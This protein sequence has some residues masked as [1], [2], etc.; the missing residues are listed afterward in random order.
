MS[1]L[2]IFDG[3][4]MSVIPTYTCG[5]CSDVVLMRPERTR[6]RVR[7]PHCWRFICEMKPICRAG[8][9]PLHELAKDHFE[10]SRSKEWGRF[11]PAIMAGA[12][13][14]EE[15]LQKGLIVSP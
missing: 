7:C 5:H 10:G 15:G 3:G 6:P 13:S 4:R 8:C 12:T 9:T 2:E 1:E 11:V 14:E